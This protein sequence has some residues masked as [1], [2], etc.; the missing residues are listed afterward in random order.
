VKIAIVSVKIVEVNVKIE[1]L[2]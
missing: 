2:L 1:Y